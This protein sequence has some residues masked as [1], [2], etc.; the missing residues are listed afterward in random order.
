MGWHRAGSIEEPASGAVL[1]Y[2]GMGF[3]AR[4]VQNVWDCDRACRSHKL[5]D[6]G[7]L[8]W[9]L[10]G[11]AYGS[12]AHEV[13]G[14]GGISREVSQ[15]SWTVNAS[16]FAVRAFLRGLLKI[17]GQVQLERQGLFGAGD[18]APGV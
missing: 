6:C 3:L 9:I 17:K 18:R 16:R 13:A 4:C 11:P 5:T 7:L 14:C 10:S 1:E 12:Q 8:V 2:E 15:I